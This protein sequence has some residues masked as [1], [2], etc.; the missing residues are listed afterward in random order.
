MKIDVSELLHGVISHRD[1]LLQLSKPCR[2]IHDGI[3]LQPDPHAS[4]PPARDF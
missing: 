4:E 2:S 1:S 3:N